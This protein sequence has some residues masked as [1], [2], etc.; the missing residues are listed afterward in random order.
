MKILCDYGDCGP[1]YV[2]SGWGRVFAACGHQFIFWDRRAKCA[3]D[4]FNEIEPDIYLGTTYD[5]DRGTAKCI[6]KR[7][8][9]KVGLYASAWGP[10]LNDI[11]TEKYPIVII[12]DEEKRNLEN[13]KRLT[14]KPDFVFIHAHDKWLDGTMSGWNE[15]GIKPI[16]LLN[17]ADIFVYLNGQRKEEFIADIAYI[18]GRW[19][20]KSRNIDANL[21]PLCHPDKKLK[22]KIFGNP[23]W[24]V[25]QWLGRIHDEDA[26]NIFVSATICPNVSESHSTDLGWDVVERP[27]KILSSGGFCISD[28]VEEAIDI[29]GDSMPYYKTP[30]ELEKLIRHFLANPDER[31]PFMKR[32]KLNVL[33]NHTYFERVYDMLK[34]FGLE[35]EC[36]KL[37]EV[38][39]KLLGS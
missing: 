15:I 13:L 3:F 19:K 31:L 22:V 4:V 17:A 37:I 25:A 29:F 33:T 34:N 24:P 32:G 8:N 12:K 35:N 6:A 20:Y 30:K 26:K 36:L 14:G 2:R 9:L 21:L 18:G 10:Y 27:F 5:I 39:G 16:G 11:D 28:S 1:Y 23:D 38:K 7:P